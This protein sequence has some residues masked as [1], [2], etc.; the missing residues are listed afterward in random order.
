MTPRRTRTRTLRAATALAAALGVLA[1]TGCGLGSDPL[2][3]GEGVDRDGSGTIVVGSANF[4]DSLLIANIY[5]EALRA[6]GFE[7]E[8]RFNIASREA[9][10]PGLVDGS[11]DLIPEYSGALLQY[12]HPGTD[13]TADEEVLAELEV[14]VPEGLAVL[15]ASAAQSKDVLVVT[16]DTAREHGLETVS[17]LV[18]LA[19]EMTLGGP[20]EWKTRYNGV[21]GLQEVY[22]LEFGTF[23]ALDA[24][25]P[26][27]L[28]AVTNGQVDV[29]DLFTTDPAIGERDLVMLEDDQGLFLAENILP[30]VREQAVDEEAREVLDAVSARLNTPDIREMMGRIISQRENPTLVARDWLSANGLA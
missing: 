18:P 3:A 7:V 16:G 10:V 19:G 29:V 11:I 23:V 15:E 5:A 28:N 6:E 1:A 25:G 22:G 17:D 20:P 30:L 12:V 9:Y 4:L 2:A 14:R 27:S 24:G 8:E 13:V 26:L 21:V